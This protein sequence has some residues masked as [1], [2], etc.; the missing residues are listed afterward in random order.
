MRNPI[1]KVKKNQIHLHLGSK[2]K[3]EEEVAQKFLLIIIV[4]LTQL[5]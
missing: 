4:N 5:C 3:V 2:I 1:Q